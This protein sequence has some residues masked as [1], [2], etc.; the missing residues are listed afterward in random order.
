VLT[1][2]DPEEAQPIITELLARTAGGRPRE[3]GPA[4][5]RT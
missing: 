1:I 4:G 2:T 3:A 5:K